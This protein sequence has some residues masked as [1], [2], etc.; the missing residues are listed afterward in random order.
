MSNLISCNLLFASAGVDRFADI[1]V[2]IFSK[3]FT[4]IRAGCPSRLAMAPLASAAIIILL[5]GCSTTRIVEVRSAKPTA[6]TVERG[7]DTTPEL[8]P[9]LQ[10]LSDEARALEPLATSDLGRRFLAATASLSAV[11]PRVVFQNPQTREYY[12]PAEIAALPDA[13]KTKL[14]QTELDEYRYY[15][16][17][18]GSPLAYVRALDI[19]SRNGF[20][21]VKGK[22]I[23]D[24]GYGSIG[25]LRLLASLGG[26]MTGVDPD[27]YLDAL[28]SEP[29]DQ[30]EVALAARKS[31][32]G[33]AGTVT[34][35]HAS[36][37][38]DGKAAERVG[39]GY[40]L[41][42][43][44]N[45]LKRGYIKPERKVDKHLMVDLGVSEDA[46]LK[47]L[48]N[49]LN[50]GGKLLIYNLYPKAAAANEKYKP[51]ADGRS[52]FSREQYEKS[53]FQ[54]LAIDREDNAAIRQIGR[55]LK[56]DQNDKNEVIDDLENNLFAMYT[57]VEKPGH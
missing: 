19:A 57:L 4:T 50:P 3:I 23:L 2:N 29:S 49:A 48:F 24:Y 36:Y 7:V 40:D 53:G 52:P 20:V 43:S 11:R 16:T 6:P 41:I 33:R 27:S 37:P 30:G 18:Y 28:Y 55:A 44:K 45:T 15:Y 31:L 5:A 1:L 21:D 35:V 38:K 42:L 26:H 46:F 25:H 56:W 12:S 8:S 34:L 51:F 32:F 9:A 47:T 39:Q 10:R 22:R 13:T 14:V 17:K 54:V